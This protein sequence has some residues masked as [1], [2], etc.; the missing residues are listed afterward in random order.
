MQARFAVH[1]YCHYNCERLPSLFTA[2][3]TSQQAV[4]NP[5]N[6]E[7]TVCECLL[8][9]VCRAAVHKNLNES[10]C[11]YL[12]TVPWHIF[13]EVFNFP[14]L[15]S[16]RQ[17]ICIEWF[18][19]CKPSGWILETSEVCVQLRSFCNLS[20]QASKCKNTAHFRLA[21]RIIAQSR[22][23][24][25]SSAHETEIGNVVQYSNTCPS[26]QRSFSINTER[27]N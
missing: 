12:I 3:T 19:T 4:Y 11:L 2:N 7:A 25:A 6:Y 14:S 10:S 26:I 17:V 1:E 9:H 16:F 21:N 23:S 8:F 27:E 5:I 24:L 18:L 15:S 22:G 20:Q 13:L